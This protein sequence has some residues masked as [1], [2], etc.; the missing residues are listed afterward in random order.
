MSTNKSRMVDAIS[1]E[2]LTGRSSRLAVMQNLTSRF[3]PRDPV[4]LSVNE[5]DVELSGSNFIKVFN[6]NCSS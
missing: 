6:M 5:R 1:K 2:L 4:S 3:I